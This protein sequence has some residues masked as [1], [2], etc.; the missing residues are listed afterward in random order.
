M[1]TSVLRD[2]AIRGYV[3]DRRCMK[4]GTFIDED[5]FE[6][7][8]DEFREIRLSERCFCQ[9]VTDIYA[10]SVDYNKDAP[11]TQALLRHRPEQAPLSRP[12]PHRRRAHPVPCP[13]L[14]SPDGKILHGDVAIGKN[15]LNRN[16]LED[17]SCLVNAFRDLAESRARR[18]TPM[19]ME[20]WAKRLDTF[21]DLDDRQILD[22]AGRIS[23]AQAD[24][25]ALSEFEKFHII[26]D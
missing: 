9:K 10:T 8:L 7:L 2:F 4:N 19:T 26:Q 1:A 25:H 11:A 22:S 15:Y 6:L 20:D 3:I 17:L 24:E 13:G 12:R 16:E 23:R 21:L 14:T 5:Y 18:Q